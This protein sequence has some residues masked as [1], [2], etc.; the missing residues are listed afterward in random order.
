[1]M[2]ATAPAAMRS[3]GFSDPSP[4]R[5]RFMF[6]INLHTFDITRIFTWSML[7]PRCTVMLAAGTYAV[8][9]PKD[10]ASSESRW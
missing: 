9:S 1:M 6:E 8:C 2:P 7:P 10:E 5:S 3:P 4:V